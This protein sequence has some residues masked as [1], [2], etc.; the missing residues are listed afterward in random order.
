MNSPLPNDPALD[1]IERYCVLTLA[2]REAA[3]Q[4]KM[5]EFSD[6]IASREEVLSTLETLPTLSQEAI[7]QLNLAMTVEDELQA[8]LK[9]KQSE[10]VTEMLQFQRGKQGH[11]TYQESNVRKAG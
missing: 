1:I 3:R 2:M 9:A 4:D 10:N 11:K 6:L 8:E 7:I 5:Q